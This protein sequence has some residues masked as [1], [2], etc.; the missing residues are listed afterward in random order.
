MNRFMN[1]T[2]EPHAFAWNIRIEIKYEMGSKS[3]P[4]KETK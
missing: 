4:D 3:D 2:A 1:V